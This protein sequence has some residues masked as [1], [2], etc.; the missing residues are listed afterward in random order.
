M[1]DCLGSADRAARKRAVYLRR[2]GH[3][4]GLHV[5]GPDPQHRRRRGLSIVDATGRRRPLLRA[6]PLHQPA[7]ARAP[8]QRAVSCDGLVRRDHPPA[9]HHRVPCVQG[10]IRNRADL[11]HL[12]VLEAV[13]GRS[14]PAQTPDPAGRPLRRNRLA[15]PQCNHAHRLRRCLAAR[16]DHFPVDL[17]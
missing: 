6:Q 7:T 14:Q 16:G 10:C 5:P 2:A 4:A 13:S 12:A 9:A 15:D 8:V 17:P 11:M 1:G 3:P